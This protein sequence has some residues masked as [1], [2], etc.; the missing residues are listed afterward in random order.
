MVTLQSKFIVTNQ[1]LELQ[2]HELLYSPL[3]RINVPATSNRLG[4]PEDPS[5]VEDPRIL[6]GELEE[7]PIEIDEFDELFSRYVCFNDE[8]LFRNVR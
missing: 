2:L 4:E 7:T 6:W 8:D 5:D 1:L 3:R